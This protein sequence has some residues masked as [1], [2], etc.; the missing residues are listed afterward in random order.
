MK[1]LIIYDSFAAGAKANAA[2][3]HSTENLAFNVQWNVRPWRLDMLRFTPTL[4]LAMAEAL[5][6]H[7]IVLASH[8]SQPF[9]VWLLTWLDHWAKC[10][11]VV[12]ATL[13]VFCTGKAMPFSSS[14]TSHLADFARRCGLGLLFV[15]GDECEDVRTI[16]I[17]GVRGLMSRT[18]FTPTHLLETR[19]QGLIQD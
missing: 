11:H 17:G 8:S 13:A 16:G 10:R 4:E 3:K 18:L 7:L 12:E 15:D 1:A 2:L 19:T 6:A 5:G 14:T 9:P